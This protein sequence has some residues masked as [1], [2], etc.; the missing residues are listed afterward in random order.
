[1]L[2]TALLATLLI[3]SIAATAIPAPQ[4]GAYQTPYCADGGELHCCE[5][6]FN[7]GN[8]LVVAASDLACYDLTP[9]TTN[10]I[11]GITAPSTK[12]EQH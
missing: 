10:C 4:W 3:Q 2:A 7:G 6:T 5:I 8:A 1:M 9:A 12:Q 11:I